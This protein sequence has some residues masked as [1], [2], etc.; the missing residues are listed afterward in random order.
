[1]PTITCDCGFKVEDEDHYAAEAKMWHHAIKDHLDMLKEMTPQQLE[2][3]IR[4]NDKQME[5]D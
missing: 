4:N 3:V 5:M 2:S 1:M